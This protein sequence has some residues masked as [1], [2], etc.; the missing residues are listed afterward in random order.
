V[1]QKIKSNG[2]KLKVS[3]GPEPGKRFSR[4][5]LEKQLGGLS[6]RQKNKRGKRVGKK[7][8]V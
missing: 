4:K 1:G 8:G 6:D 3:E 2:T 5:N 7:I